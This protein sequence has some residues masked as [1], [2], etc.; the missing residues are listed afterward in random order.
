MNIVSFK[1]EEVQNKKEPAEIFLK[2]LLQKGEKELKEKLMTRQ[3]AQK[4]KIEKNL[5]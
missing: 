3:D 1:T 2:Y 4:G 5:F